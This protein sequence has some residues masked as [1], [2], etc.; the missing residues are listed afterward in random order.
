MITGTTT[1]YYNDKGPFDGSFYSIASGQ[2]GLNTNV[3]IELVNTR[4]WE[5]RPHITMWCIPVPILVDPIEFEYLKN[6]LDLSHG[7][8]DI[9]QHMA[10]YH[11]DE[12]VGEINEQ[13]DVWTAIDGSLNAH[14]EIDIWYNGPEISTTEPQ[15]CCEIV[16][17]QHGDGSVKGTYSYSANLTDGST[18]RTDV[19][20]YYNYTTN[21]TLPC[22]E[23][24]KFTYDRVEVTV[25]GLSYDGRGDYK[26]GVNL[27]ID[28][29]RGGFGGVT[30]T[31]INEGPLS[32]EPEPETY[33]VRININ[34]PLMIL[35]ADTEKAFD[36]PIP[37]GEGIKVKSGFVLGFGPATITVELEAFGPIITKEA[38]GLVILFFVLVS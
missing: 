34:A 5:W 29:I 18:F 15:E 2:G 32:Y 13:Y 9:H 38:N 28:S 17:E 19:T 16:L 25:N 6:L 21:E 12:L 23:I 3:N 1:Y 31:I 26:P 20:R 22:P 36:D 7:N 30:A 24:L 33:T 37:L 35:G 10:D 8:L 27:A 14:A 4:Y 11:N